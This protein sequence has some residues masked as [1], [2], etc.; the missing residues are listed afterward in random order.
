MVRSL[1]LNTGLAYCCQIG[2]S[3][4][5]SAAASSASAAAATPPLPPPSSTA[6]TCRGADGKRTAT[7]V[8]SALRGAHATTSH[9][10]TLGI[11]VRVRRVRRWA[12]SNVQA[13]QRE[14]ARER[15]G[16]KV[17][18]RERASEREERE[19]ERETARPST[20]HMTHTTQT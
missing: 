1:V 3:R 5:P 6:S 15:E 8:S 18:S 2:G 9:R 12:R 20:A 16:E 10:A 14:R 13:L 19:R 7:T 17:R 4:T 11:L